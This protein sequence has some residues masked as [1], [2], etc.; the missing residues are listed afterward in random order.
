MANHAF[1]VEPLS[2]AE[3]AIEHAN[4]A[5]SMF[6]WRSE[7]A[8]VLGNGPLGLLALG[9]LTAGYDRLYCLGR[10]DRPNPTID[11]IEGLGARYVDSRR[12]PVTAFADVHEPVDPAIEAT[13]YAR[14]TFETLD[15]LAP[16]GAGA[17]LGI[18]DD[19]SFE[20]EGGRRHRETVSGNKLLVGSVNANA[21]HFDLASDS[22]S[23]IPDRVLDDLVTGRFAPDEVADAFR[24]EEHDIKSV[25]EFATLDEV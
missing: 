16:N 13:G 2:N 10:C 20:I 1:L 12:T 3:K 6:D 23:S 21:R 22:L 4:V 7:S 11:I 9:S 25:V 15:V 19:Q 14:H 17:L 18:P 24:T 5:R 8:L